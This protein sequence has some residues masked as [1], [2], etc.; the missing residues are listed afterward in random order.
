MDGL[1]PSPLFRLS[2][3]R[4]FE[5][6]KELEIIGRWA[7]CQ[8]ASEGL[9]VK[10]L[11]KPYHPGGSDDWAKFKTIFEIKVTVLEAS[12]KKNGFSYLCGLRDP[13]AIADRTQLRSLNGK[14]YLALG[15]TF[16]TQL[17]SQAWGHPERSHRRAANSEQRQRG[18]QNFMGKTH[19]SRAGCFERCLFRQLRR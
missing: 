19:S 8:Y 2:E 10:D 18:G 5:T 16:V 1:K 9:M 17:Q 6:E 13:P 11:T 12:E 7:A 14:D 15:S 4:R 3:P